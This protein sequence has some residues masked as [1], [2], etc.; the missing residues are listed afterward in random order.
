MI[1]I[2]LSPP[3]L[4][5]VFHPGQNMFSYKNARFIIIFVK[6]KIFHTWLISAGLEPFLSHTKKSC[7]ALYY[8]KFFH[9]YWN[10]NHKKSLGLRRLARYFVTDRQI[11]S[12]DI[13]SLLNKDRFWL[14]PNISSIFLIVSYMIFLL[15]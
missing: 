8:R 11:D 10:E 12:T 2:Q 7:L 5:E 9:E 14:T 4:L 3:S 13:I 6:V 15:I 1:Y